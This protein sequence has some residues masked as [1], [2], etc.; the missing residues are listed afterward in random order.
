MTE[1]RDKRTGEAGPEKSAKYGGG[2]IPD[3]PEKDTEGNAYGHPF[4]EGQPGEPARAV[5]HPLTE[6][7]NP[8]D[9]GTADKGY[10]GP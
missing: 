8:D 7:E 10:R 4:T 3:E 9:A 5:G 1:Q 2:A 6:P